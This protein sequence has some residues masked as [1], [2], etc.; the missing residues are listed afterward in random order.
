M[1]S[2]RA[3][4]DRRPDLA[5]FIRGR[6]RPAYMPYLTVGDPN[7]AATV[8]FAVRMIDAGADL[9]EL[10][11]PF[12]DPT[13]DGPV[14]QAAMQR[15]LRQPDFSIERVF[16]VARAIH[17]A[18]P[19]IP[20]ILLTYLNPVLT[21]FLVRRGANQAT[22]NAFD[23]ASNLRRFLQECASSGVAGLVIPDLPHDQPEAQLLR[24]LGPD[25]GVH[26]ILMVAPN[27][28]ERR[29]RGIC[30]NASGFIYYVTSLGVTGER[31]G[32]PDDLAQNVE[33]VR[34]ESGLPVLAGFGISKP[35]Q[36]RTLRGILDGVIVG[37]LHHRLIEEQGTQAGD[38]LAQATAAF[39]S[40]LGG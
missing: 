30:R 20:L 13:A 32:L 33:R 36:A 29:F 17:E 21:G 4:V 26:Q 2:E 39:V 37:S 35:E 15:A 6:G 38:A 16:E 28:S 12:S 1:H 9:M 25:H 31:S 27:T 23:P 10:G 18:R 34:R 14:I 19:N 24:R 3:I 40:A 22:R 11:I 7:F 8:D 5:A